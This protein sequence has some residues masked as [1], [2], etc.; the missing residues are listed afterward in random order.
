[1][2]KTLAHDLPSISFGAIITSGCSVTNTLPGSVTSTLPIALDQISASE[3]QRQR[4]ILRA[5]TFIPS[6]FFVEDIQILYQGSTTVNSMSKGASLSRTYS[7]SGGALGQTISPIKTTKFTS[8][9]SNGFAEQDGITV[10]STSCGGE[11]LLGIN[12]IAQSSLGSSIDISKIV[13]F[14]GKL[15]RC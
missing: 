14:S 1:M 7:F 6:G 8:N 11:G 12:I 15:S 3:G 2:T 9:G 4:C 5:Q 10:L 13:I